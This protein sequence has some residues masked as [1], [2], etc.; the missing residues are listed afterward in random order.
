LAV[1]V[2]GNGSQKIGSSSL[3]GVQGVQL[4]ILD[5]G[6]QQLLDENQTPTPAVLLSVG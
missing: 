1:S 4:L 6:F 3:A 2:A 5:D